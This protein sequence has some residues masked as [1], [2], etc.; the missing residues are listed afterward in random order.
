MF[1]LFRT[2]SKPCDTCF[3]GVRIVYVLL[4]RC[5]TSECQ[6]SAICVLVSKAPLLPVF[7]VCIFL[8]GI[9][10]KEGLPFVPVDALE[11]QDVAWDVLCFGWLKNCNFCALFVFQWR[12]MKHFYFKVWMLCEIPVM[13]SLLFFL[14]QELLSSSVMSIVFWLCSHITGRQIT[15]ELRVKEK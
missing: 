11:G 8:R 10:T 1:S 15:W 14:K 4:G 3:S 5:F 7:P 9:Q 6:L 13:N 12:T 2:P